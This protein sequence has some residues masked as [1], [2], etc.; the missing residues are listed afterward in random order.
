MKEYKNTLLRQLAML[1]PI[2]YNLRP[3]CIICKVETYYLSIRSWY[4]LMIIFFRK[5]KSF[6]DI[7]PVQTLVTSD[8]V[9]WQLNN[10]M[11]F[12]VLL[13]WIN[14]Y[15]LPGVDPAILKRGVPAKK[16]G[17]TTCPH[18]NALIVQKKRGGGIQERLVYFALQPESLWW[19]NELFG[20]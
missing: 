15:F 8:I 2:I 14:P 16:G 10:L 20:V 18:S 5:D 9:I 1:V 13:M 11:S 4:L 6:F 7:P 17:I 3:A 19:L 12:F